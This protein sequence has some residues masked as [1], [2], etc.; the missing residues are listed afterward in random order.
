MENIAHLER[1]NSAN[2]DELGP[3]ERL[4]L[5]LDRG[6]EVEDLDGDFEVGVCLLCFCCRGVVGNVFLEL[7]R[8]P[9]QLVHLTAGSSI[10][11][12]NSPISPSLH[13]ELQEERAAASDGSVTQRVR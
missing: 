2:A 1:Q 4:V 12:F 5:L 8:R 9:A 11:I 3:F 7:N 6:G 10:V 13:A